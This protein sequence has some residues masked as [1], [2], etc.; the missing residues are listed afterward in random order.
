MGKKYIEQT[1]TELYSIYDKSIH[2][3]N[4]LYDLKVIPDIDFKQNVR[5]KLADFFP[6]KGTEKYKEKAKSIQDKI[7]ERF[8]IPMT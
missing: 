7:N 4:Y 3:I 8:K 2:I 5:E 6:N 1:I